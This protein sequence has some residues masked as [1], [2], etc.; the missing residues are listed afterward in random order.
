MDRGQA[1]A[2]AD[3]KM[4]WG[5]AYVITC[6]GGVWQAVNRGYGHTLTATGAHELRLK[7]REDYGRNP[8]HHESMSL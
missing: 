8:V 5:D 3:L 1:T 7:I 4:H 6:E 2:L